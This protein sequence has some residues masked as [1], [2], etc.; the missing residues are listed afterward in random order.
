MK[1]REGLETVEGLN[2]CHFRELAM[3]IYTEAKKFGK[4]HNLEVRFFKNFMLC[5]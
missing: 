3:Q 2:R 5:G 4:V 1:K